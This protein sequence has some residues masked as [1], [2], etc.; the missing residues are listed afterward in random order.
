MGTGIMFFFTGVMVFVNFP[1]KDLAVKHLDG[2]FFVPNLVY[3]A[4]VLPCILAAWGIGRTVK[5]EHAAKQLSI[6]EKFER[7][8]YARASDRYVDTD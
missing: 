7:S 2:N 5:R 8:D 6:R 4:L 3:M 1:M